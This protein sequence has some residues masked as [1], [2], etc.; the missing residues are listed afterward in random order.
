MAQYDTIFKNATLVNH[1]G[2][3]R[4]DIG[5]TTGRIA[6]SQAASDV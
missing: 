1:D 6:A 4:A 3:S 2:E 5:V